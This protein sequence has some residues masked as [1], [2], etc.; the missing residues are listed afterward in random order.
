M[1]E[2]R[3]GVLDNIYEMK[4]P[5]FDW[6]KNHLTCFRPKVNFAMQPRVNNDL[7]NISISQIN[8]SFRHW[9]EFSIL[10][11]PFNFLFICFK[12]FSQFN[13]FLFLWFSNLELIEIQLKNFLL[14]VFVEKIKRVVSMRGD[15]MDIWNQVYLECLSFFMIN[16]LLVAL[17]RIYGALLK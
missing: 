11:H 9:L 15:H 7:I 1:S 10:F 12:L 6:L 4:M 2:L 3:G 8:D 17:E 13:N 16:Y 5:K 14:I